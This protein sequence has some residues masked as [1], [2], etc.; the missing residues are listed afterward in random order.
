MGEH[1]VLVELDG[2]A[3]VQRLRAAALA[4]GIAREV[5]AGWRTLL[6]TGDGTPGELAGQVEQLD[7]VAGAAVAARHHE[8]PSTTTERTCPQW[9]RRAD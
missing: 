8:V 7:T 4:A 9:P 1:S 6:L 2:P 3:A 5:V